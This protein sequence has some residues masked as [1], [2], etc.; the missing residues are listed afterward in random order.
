MNKNEEFISI[1]FKA[2]WTI[3][4][5]EKW[6]ILSLTTL[7]TI[8]GGF[9]AFSLRAEF[10]S[11]GKILPE[12]ANKGGSMGQ[13]AG[14]AALAGVD[15][16]SAASGTDAVRPDLYPDVIKSTPFFVNL[17]Q[18][19]V[20]DRTGKEVKVSDFYD[21]NILDNKFKKEDKKSNF[22]LSDKYV[23][24]DK[25]T[26]KSING[27]KERVTCSYD[28]KTG[29]ISISVKMPDPVVAASVTKYSMDYLTDYIIN[30][31]TEKLKRDLDFL[32]ERLDIA[33]GKYYNKQESKASY[34]DRVPLEALRFQAAD[35]QRE[36]IEAEYKTASSFY[37]TLLQKYEEAKLKV[38]Q[39][40]P[41]I[42][43]LEPAV[44]PNLKAE[45][46]KSN[47]LIGFFFIGGMVSFL[48]SLLKN[49]NYKQIFAH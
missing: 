40:T 20:K 19:K 45:P 37:S 17:L 12:V 41:V 21:S 31:R 27:L 18:A 34:S 39:E 43:V 46:K 10:V 9:Y 30:Y 35:L 29:V 28:R 3:L 42:K 13:F 2:L 8:L 26:E 6:L 36:R 23:V 7:I 32:A 1:N 49:K 22:Q 33:K 16:G 15:L 47:I 5:K 44:V 38:Q 24:L 48:L 14:L 25:H 11:Q 4:K